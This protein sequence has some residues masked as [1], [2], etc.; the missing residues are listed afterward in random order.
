MISTRHIMKKSPAVQEC[1]VVQLWLTAMGRLYGMSVVRATC[2]RMQHAPAIYDCTRLGSVG[3][4]KFRQNMT[5]YLGE[6]NV[7]TVFTKAAARNYKY[8]AKVCSPDTV[9]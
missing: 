7:L 4:S 3:D 5:F 2:S 1:D 8:A 6:R 9:D